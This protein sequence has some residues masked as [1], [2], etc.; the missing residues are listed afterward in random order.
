MTTTIARRTEAGVLER[1]VR[2]LVDT[3]VELV[4]A[5]DDTAAPT[6]AGHAIVYNSRTAI[7]NPLTW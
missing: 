6:F 2:P 7:G 3:D 4:R 5:A 1:R